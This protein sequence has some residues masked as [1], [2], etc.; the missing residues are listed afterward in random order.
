MDASQFISKWRNYAEKYSQW[1]APVK[2]FQDDYMKENDLNW[3]DYEQINKAV[4]AFR[5]ERKAKDDLPC[6]IYDFLD[7][8]IHLYLEASPEERDAIRAVPAGNR[9]FSEIVWGYIVHA[10][11]NLAESGE[12]DW[13]LRGVVMI[14]I[15]NLKSDWRD[16]LV[17]LASIYVEAE[18]HGLSPQPVLNAVAK[19]SSMEKPKWSDTSMASTLRHFRSYGALKEARRNSGLQS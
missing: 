2:K 16:T 11:R 4:L 3:G 7:E 17:N 6:E 10:K 1:C 19:A 5:E 9:D 14:S 15:E 8:H 12:E 13:L 18:R